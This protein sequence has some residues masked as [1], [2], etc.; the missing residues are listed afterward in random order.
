MRVLVVRA[1]TDMLGPG[2]VRSTDELMRGTFESFQL[3]DWFSSSV[4][5]P[6]LWFQPAAWLKLL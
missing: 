2:S 1:D 5:L 3:A 6:K 4:I